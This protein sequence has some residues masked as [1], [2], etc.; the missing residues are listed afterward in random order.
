MPSRWLSLLC[1]SSSSTARFTGCGSGRIARNRSARSR[2]KGHP[3]HPDGVFC[4]SSSSKEPAESDLK[5]PRQVKRDHWGWSPSCCEHL[6]GAESAAL[7]RSFG[8]LL[9][10]FGKI[11]RTVRPLHRSTDQFGPFILSF[12]LWASFSI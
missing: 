6:R 3:V 11:R 9:S 10:V 5:S 8:H 1:R 12:T 4:C 7:P 2:N